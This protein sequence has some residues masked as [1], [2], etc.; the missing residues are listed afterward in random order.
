MSN[1]SLVANSRV[2]SCG[3]LA[4][5]VAH[6]VGLSKSEEDEERELQKQIEEIFDSI[7]HSPLDCSLEICVVLLIVHI[8]M[9]ELCQTI[10]HHA[11]SWKENE[12]MVET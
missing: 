10:S 6:V 9:V 1:P 5:G 2:W 7:F 8:P 3:T 12:H 11:R 4:D